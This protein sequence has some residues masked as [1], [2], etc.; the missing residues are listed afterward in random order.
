MLVLAVGAVG[1]QLARSQ[2]VQHLRGLRSSELDFLPEVA[3][4]IQ[5]FRRVKMEGDRKAWEVAAREAQYFEDDREIVVDEPEVH[6]YL[7]GDQG[8]VSIKGNEG[9]ISMSGREM[10]KVVLEGG[11]E[12]RFRDYLVKTERAVYERAADTVMSPT[13][14]AI[15]GSGLALTGGRMTVEIEGQRLRLEGQVETVLE[16]TR[17]GGNAGAGVL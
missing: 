9:T 14:V 6:L 16:Q 17:E 2:W 15:T 5:N 12:I 1:V 3:Q 10:D 7:K 8:S 11:I 13:G 4:R